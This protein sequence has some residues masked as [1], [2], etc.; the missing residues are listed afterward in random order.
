M[1]L[2]LVYDYGMLVDRASVES[3]L[4]DP[5]LRKALRKWL[6]EPSDADD[7]L[8]L[9]AEKLVREQI[10]VLTK[11]YLYT[12]ARNAAIDLQRANQRREQNAKGMLLRHGDDAMP[13][14][15]QSLQAIEATN[16]I[17][18]ILDRQA[19]LNR[20]I[21]QLYHIQNMTQP[22]IARLLNLHLSTVEKRLSKVRKAC[23]QELR[24]HL[25]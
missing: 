14:P 8:Q 9:V 22:E 1:R 4:S 5:A 20:R 11:G 7:V 12:V 13:A 19:P 23:L 15:E 25:D 24:A 18:A 2:L 6:H 21:F 16:A 17:Q 10:P 3:L